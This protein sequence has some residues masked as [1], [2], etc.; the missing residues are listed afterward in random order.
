MNSPIE[1]GKRLSIFRE[2]MGFPKQSDFLS[3]VQRKAGKGISQG[4]LSHWEAGR[5]VPKM[6]KLTILKTAFPMLNLEWL[7]T[8]SGEMLTAPIKAPLNNSLKE[9]PPSPRELQLEVENSRLK[10]ELIQALKKL[11]GL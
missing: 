6:D 4:N 10:D 3:E 7:L 1:V 5:Y 2:S 11:N 9:S 8:G